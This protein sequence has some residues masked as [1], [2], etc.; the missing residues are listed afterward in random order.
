MENKEE[1]CYAWDN[2]EHNWAVFRG[3]WLWWRHYRLCISCHLI[4]RTK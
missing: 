4:E 3:T 2:Y 1:P